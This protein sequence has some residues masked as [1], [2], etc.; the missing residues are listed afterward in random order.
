MDAN[1]HGLLK[2][3]FAYFDGVMTTMFVP[4]PYEMDLK[5]GIVKNQPFIKTKM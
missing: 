3:L 2:R 4:M 1:N 5:N